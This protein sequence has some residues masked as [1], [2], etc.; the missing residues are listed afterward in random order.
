MRVAAVQFEPIFGEKCRNFEKIKSY[1]DTVEADLIVFPELATTGYLFL[2]KEESLEFAESMTEKTFSYMRDAARRTGKILC[3]GF[4]EKDGANVFNSAATLFPE[5]GADFVYR[6]SHLFYKERFAFEPGN[7]GY[8][9][10]RDE[11]SGANIGTMICYDWRFPEAARTLAIRGA[12]L[13]LCPSNLVTGVWHGALATRALENKTYLIVA[14]RNGEETRGGETVAFNG[15]S[16]IYGY[17]GSV[18]AEASPDGEEVIYA[19][20]EPEKTRDKKFNEFND[21]FEDRRT[22]LYER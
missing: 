13:I 16:K 2:S 18:L 12:D 8:V 21:I 10:D 19:E 17:N 15:A 3:F 20:I 4:A 1:V 5:P 9:V 6:K 7:T 11:K 14:N 22:D